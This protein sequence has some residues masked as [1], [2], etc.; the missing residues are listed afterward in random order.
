MEEKLKLKIKK[1]KKKIKKEI[2]FP[3]IILFENI[4]FLKDFL[5]AMAILD[6]LLMKR[7]QGLAFG[8]DF[9]HDLLIKM[10]HI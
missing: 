9:L 5:H 1:R 8:A 10:F 3:N 6:Y 2:L 7:G 4:L